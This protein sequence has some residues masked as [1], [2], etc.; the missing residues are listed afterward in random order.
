MTICSQKRLDNVVR[1]DC[2]VKIV[3]LLL[4]VNLTASFERPDNFGFIEHKQPEYIAALFADF[5][6][7]PIALGASHHYLL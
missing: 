7:M 1:A 6:S 2:R 4:W 5:A 3:L